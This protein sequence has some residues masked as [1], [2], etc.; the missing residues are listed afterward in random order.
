MDDQQKPAQLKSWSHNMI[1]SCETLL[2]KTPTRWDVE[3]CTTEE[4]PASH[5]LTHPECQGGEWFWVHLIK[6]C[7]LLNSWA[8]AMNFMSLL[9]GLGGDMKWP[10]NVNV[11]CEWSWLLWRE[12]DYAQVQPGGHKHWKRRRTTVHPICLS[13][14]DVTSRCGERKL[15]VA[16]AQVS[17]TELQHHALKSENRP[18]A[19]GDNC[20]GRHD[21]A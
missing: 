10:A 1:V 8:G 13:G 16:D 15:R 7:G 12:R 20:C 14:T 11:S 17:F 9:L 6:A 2:P 18:L 3:G 21:G 19:L 4:C 5:Q